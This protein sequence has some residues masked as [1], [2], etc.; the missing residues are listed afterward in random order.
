MVC[1]A[2]KIWTGGQSGCRIDVLYYEGGGGGGE[3]KG[4]RWAMGE[5]RA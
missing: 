3:G 1:E 5:G 2:G 4:D